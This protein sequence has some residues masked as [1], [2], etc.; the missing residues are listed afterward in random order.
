LAREVISAGIVPDAYFN[1][2][3]HIAYAV[4]YELDV[5]L[6]YNYKHPVNMEVEF[7]L[8]ELLARSG[9]KVIH[10]RTPAEVVIYD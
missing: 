7:A 3:V 1:D 8:Q 10:I 5:L 4:L 2:A 6:S 9:E